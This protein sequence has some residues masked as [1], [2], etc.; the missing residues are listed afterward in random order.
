[1]KT[2]TRFIPAA[3]LAIGGLVLL[4]KPAAIAMPLRHDLSSLPAVLDG[5]SSRELTISAEEVKVSGTT[6][7]L[8]R[9]YGDRLN[10][11]FTLYV[12]YHAAQSQSN[13]MHSPRNCL[14]GAGWQV[15]TSGAVRAGDQMVNR[16]LIEY[17]GTK[18]L[19]LYW[20]QGRGRV[21]ADEFQV[22]LHL[23]ADASRTGRTEEALVRLVIP[24][25][26]S[27]T[28]GK[29]ATLPTEPEAERLGVTMATALIPSIHA[30]LP[31]PPATT[32]ATVQTAALQPS[33]TP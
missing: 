13:Q 11:E 26:S 12:G 6:A 9:A 17:K 15:L 4:A 20:Y 23:F 16:Y 30:L 33:R 8:L 7:H 5:R 21:T 14:P 25:R 31:A 29:T 32:S 3:L 24:V 2:S 22:K 10:P 27:A 19:V 28:D 1:M 18:A